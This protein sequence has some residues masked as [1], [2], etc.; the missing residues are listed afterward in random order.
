MTTQ[1]HTRSIEKSGEG[2]DAEYAASCSCRT[3]YTSRLSTYAAAV[4]V[5]RLHKRDVAD[6]SWAAEQAAKAAHL[7]ALAPLHDA[8]REHFEAKEAR[9]S[10]GFAVIIAKQRGGDVE[11]ARRDLEAAKARLEAAEAA[12]AAV[13]V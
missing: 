11:A 2:E 13:S 7:E 4:E 1:T 5:D 10:A 8:Q 3:V 12:L 6:G 9:Q